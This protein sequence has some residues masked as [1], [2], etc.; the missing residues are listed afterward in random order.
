MPFYWSQ[1]PNLRLKPAPR[2]DYGKNHLDACQNHFKEL[3]EKYGEIVAVN[4]VN[5]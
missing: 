5:I 1:L 2:L 3:T 4:L